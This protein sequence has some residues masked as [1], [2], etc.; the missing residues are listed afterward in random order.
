[1]RARLSLLLAGQKVRLRDIDMN[2]KP[3][4][5]MTASAKG[6]VPVLIVASSAIETPPYVVDESLEIM[7][8]ALNKH[9]PHNLL[10]K[11]DL[12]GLDNMLSL[13]HES[14]VDFVSQLYKYKAAS[15]YRDSDKVHYREQCAPFIE[16]IEQRLTT[17]TFLMRNKPSLAD[18]ALLPFL[19]QFSKVER[20]WFLQAPLPKLQQWLSRLYQQAVYSKAM[21]PIAKYAV[22]QTDFIF[23]LD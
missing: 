15:R 23:G 6:T 1:M 16:A 17:H 5:L 20:K 12:N 19:R 18:Y 2:N 9:D 14:D 22:G 4:A 13:I 10:L 8:W 3:E 21:T 11:E 7:L